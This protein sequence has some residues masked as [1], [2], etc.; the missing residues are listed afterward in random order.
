MKTSAT[1]CSGILLASILITLPIEAQESV[2][3]LSY[4]TFF[5]SL[6]FLHIVGEVQNNSNTALSYVQ[7][8]GTLYDSSNTV[9]D[10]AFTYTSLDIIPKDAKS[11]FEILFMN[12]EQA[13][14]ATKYG[15]KVTGAEPVAEKQQGLRIL[16]HSSFKDA[17]GFLHV[18]GEI[19]NDGSRSTE[20]VEII[21][22]FYDNKGKV[23]ATGFTYTDKESLASGEVASFNLVLLQTSQ[24]QL[25]TNYHL[26][27]ESEEYSMI[28]KA[29]PQT[30]SSE[31]E[32]VRTDKTLYN[33]G[34]LVSISGK[35]VR[36]KDFPSAPVSVEV[37]NPTGKVFRTLHA[38][39]DH[40]GK[41]E[42][43]FYLF[44]QKFLDAGDWKIKVRYLSRDVAQTTFIVIEKSESETPSPQITNED[45]AVPK[46]LKNI[47]I[48][49]KVT[50]K[51]LRDL[52][53][54]SVK[55]S[56]DSSDHIFSI[57]ITVNDGEITGARAPKNWEKRYTNS[58]E[59]VFSAGEIGVQVQPGAKERF[60]LKVSTASPTITW[61][62]FNEELQM[63]DTGVVKPFLLKPPKVSEQPQVVKEESKPSQPSKKEEKPKL[64][65]PSTGEASKAASLTQFW[66]LKEGDV[67][68]ARVSLMDKDQS[69][70][71]ESGKV[72]FGIL[73]EQGNALYSSEF[74]VKKDDFKE[75]QLVLTGAKIYAYAWTFPSSDVKPPQKQQFSLGIGTAVLQFTTTDGRTL[76]IDYKLVEL[77]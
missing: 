77:P 58:E 22:T 51:Q 24:L 10:T 61:A 19:K 30:S 42:T 73:D 6:G 38:D 64:T 5:D 47:S 15:I 59:V 27:A 39:L 55:N 3:I 11:P 35:V 9:V 31:G 67:Y 57:K 34:E 70:I 66:V 28:A 8:S 26:T 43:G 54:L 63:M 68:R 71:G 29:T 33:K 44:G 16:S 32:Y 23:V 65:C 60:R 17:I 7:I 2:S 69:F 53:A 36:H 49:A 76:N 75:Y 40:E 1:L 25:I 20:Y 18:V 52:V 72:T 46:T 12:A 45:V 13:K 4:S 62:V 48:S 41:F 50:A 74:C 37:V 14:K 56:A 21:A